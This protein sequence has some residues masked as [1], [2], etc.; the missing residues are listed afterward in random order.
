MNESLLG[1]S[2]DM[3]WILANQGKRRNIECIYPSVSADT[4]FS[5]TTKLCSCFQL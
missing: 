5:N 4:H 3:C 1:K 2:E